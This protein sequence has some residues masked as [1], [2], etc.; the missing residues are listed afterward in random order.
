M[1]LSR[2]VLSAVSLW[3]CAVPLAAQD[4][5]KFGINLRVFSATQVGVTWRVSP[6]IMLRPAVGFS[7]TEVTGIGGST[8]E[9]T[10]VSGDLDVLFRGA[11]WDRVTTY[12][13]VGVGY[14][15]INSDFADA[16]A[17]AV[18]GLLGARVRVVSRVGIFGEIGVQYRDGDDPIGTTFET[19]TFPIG[20]V[21]FLQ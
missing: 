11:T 13:G 9:A 5:G 1:Q 2:S 15:T 8:V 4:D 10:Q 16:G 7:W 17:W 14:F 20:V 18:R 6:A 19:V 12:Y 21:V 3:L